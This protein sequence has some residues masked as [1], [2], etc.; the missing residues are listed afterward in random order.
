MRGGEREGV[1]RSVGEGWRGVGVLVRD[2]GGWEC[3]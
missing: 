2:G 1:G 3:W